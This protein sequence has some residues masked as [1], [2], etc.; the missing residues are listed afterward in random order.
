MVEE[1]IHLIEDNGDQKLWRFE[2]NGDFNSAGDV[3][4]SS[5]KYLNNSVQISEL[6]G[7]VAFFA[8]TTPPSGWLKANGAA[9]SRTTYAALFAAIGTTFGAG[10]GSS[11]FNLPDLR[12]EFVRGL[13]D[14]PQC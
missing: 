11:T 9:V 4:T 13:D 6:V 5:G 14:G 12:G 8:R 1:C 10:D 3:S 7:E 2:H